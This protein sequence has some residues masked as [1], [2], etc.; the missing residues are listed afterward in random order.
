MKQGN[1]SKCA[2][3]VTGI[4][5]TIYTVVE[6]I[7]SNAEVHGTEYAAKRARKD[8]INMDTVYYALFGKWPVRRIDFK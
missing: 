5:Y 4:P 2:V 6:K 8:G 3:V 1:S 7:R